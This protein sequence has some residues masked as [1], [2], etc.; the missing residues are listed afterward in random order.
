MTI[1]RTFPSNYPPP[2][3]IKSQKNMTKPLEIKCQKWYYHID[4]II[5][6]HV[7]VDQGG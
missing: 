6:H 1:S 2:P 4:E 5:K 3:A 7:T